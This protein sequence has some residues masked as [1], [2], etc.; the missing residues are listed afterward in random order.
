MPYAWRCTLRPAVIEPAV[1]RLDRARIASHRP[2]RAA[3]KAEVVVSRMP[4]ES[5][6]VRE[7]SGLPVVS[8]PEEID[9]ANAGQFRAAMLAAGFAH[10]TIIVDLSRTEFCDSSAL[11]VL[12][13]ALRRAQSEGGEVRLVVCTAPVARILA[14]TGVGSLFRVFSKLDDALATS[15][16][17]LAAAT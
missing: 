4:A 1:I 7:I 5:F 17:E 14:V 13:R 8:A 15:P 16:P 3:D 2:A 10:S 11:S 6:S 12:V 9:V